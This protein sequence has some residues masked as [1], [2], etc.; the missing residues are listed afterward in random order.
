M[1]ECTFKP[2]INAVPER[3]DH[4]KEEAGGIGEHL[5]NTQ[6]VYNDKVEKRKE[7]EEKKVKE[8]ASKKH[9]GG[10]SA[11]LLEKSEREKFVEIFKALDSDQD[12]VISASNVD[13]TR[14]PLFSI[15]PILTISIL[16][17]FSS[18]IF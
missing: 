15:I 13:I 8:M 4:R 9:T 5:Y 17:C 1:N 16:C 11:Q 3:A 6:K 10:K 12:G 2:K 14:T 18:Y 7:E